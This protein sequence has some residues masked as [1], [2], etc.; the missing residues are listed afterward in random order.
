[1]TRRRRIAHLR[2]SATFAGWLTKHPRAVVYA[3]VVSAAAIRGVY[4]FELNGT[5]LLEA[6]Q[7][8]QTDM[9]Y[10]DGWGRAIA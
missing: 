10:Y 6:H 3:L 7:I 8:T 5:P 1:M 9:H 2:P 4:W